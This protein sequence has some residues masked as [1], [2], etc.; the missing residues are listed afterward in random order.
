[1]DKQFG[2]G[3]RLVMDGTLASP[4]TPMTLVALGKTVTEADGVTALWMQKHNSHAA[5]VRPDHYTFGTASTQAELDQLLA[6]WR[7]TWPS[8]AHQHETE[9]ATSN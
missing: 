4:G 1:M 2:H 9:T 5:I 7:K 3:W 6:D 8:S